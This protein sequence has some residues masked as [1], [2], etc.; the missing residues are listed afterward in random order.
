[1]DSLRRL[2]RRLA[3]VVRP[4]SSEPDLTREAASRLAQ[5]ED[6]VPGGAPAR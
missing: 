1:M 3:H 5:L 6:D 2:L 4:H